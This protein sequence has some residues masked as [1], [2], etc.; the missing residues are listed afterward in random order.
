MSIRKW[1]GNRYRLDLKIR[2]DGE[3]FRLTKVVDSVK[4]AKQLEAEFRFKID[5]ELT[6]SKLTPFNIYG[7]QYIDNLIGI[8][9][10]TK[11]TY[12]QKFNYLKI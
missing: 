12:Q 1:K 7:Q 10:R 3:V 11:H 5:N 2:K 6:V 9:A 8:S 4:E